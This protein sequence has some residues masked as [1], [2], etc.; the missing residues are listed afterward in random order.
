MTDNVSSAVNRREMFHTRQAQSLFLQFV[1]I[2][3]CK[4]CEILI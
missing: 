2:Y 4:I 3:C 1:D